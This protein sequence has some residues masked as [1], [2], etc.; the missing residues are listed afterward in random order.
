MENNYKLEK[1]EFI[2]LISLIMINKLI[3][4][5]PYYIIELVGSGAITNII[6]VGIIDFIITLIIIKMFDNFESSDILDIS[7]FLGGN[8]LKNLIGIFSIILFFIV[9]F[10][11]LVDFSNVLQTIYFS[12]FSNIYILIF[13]IIGIL[14]VN[15]IGFKSIIRNICFIIPFAIISVIVT[16]F[17]VSGNLDVN[18]L[19]PLLG[20][21]YHKTFI[22]GL[23]NTFS[24]YIIVYLYFTKP[25]L[26]DSS[27]FKKVS[28][29]SYIISFSLLILTVI[30]MLTLF[31]TGSSSEPINSLFLLSRQIELGQFIQ[32]VDAI[33][34]LLWIFSI[35]SYLS[36]VIFLINRIIKKI[37]N[38]SNEKMLS[39]PICSILFGLTL[40]PVNISQIHFIENTLYK[41][42][43]LAFMFG[44]GIIIL[45]LANLKRIRH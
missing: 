22:V 11:T 43:I 25:L 14:C 34:I 3:L 5:I 18:N 32:R 40:I 15:F 28:I 12:D 45:V 44:V 26:K 17:A 41:Y 4:N 16:F 27:S 39:Y 38:I 1:L 29:I 10:I 20:E 21:S 6:Y 24:M 2:A 35:F 37:T 36:F 13:F 31:N 42:L 7:N 19:T 23:S 8:I 9:S 33:F 30:S